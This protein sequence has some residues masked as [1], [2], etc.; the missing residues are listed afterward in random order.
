MATSGTAN[1]MPKCAKE[2]VEGWHDTG[3][4]DDLALGY[5]PSDRQRGEDED[6]QNDGHGDE[7]A[8]WKLPTWVP[9]VVNMHGIHLDTGV[10][11]EAVDDQDD[12]GDSCPCGQEMASIQRGSRVVSCSR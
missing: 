11:E 1:L 9:Q 8:P 6:G 12:T 2:T 10:G 7:D 3:R 5:H 4:E